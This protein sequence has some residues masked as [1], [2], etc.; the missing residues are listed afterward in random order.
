MADYRH[1]QRPDELETGSGA[2]PV[3]DATGDGDGAGERS[4]GEPSIHT[5]AR[6]ALEAD[7]S[8]RELVPPPVTLTD[9]ADEVFSVD[10][11]DDRARLEPGRMADP[12]G[13]P[14]EQ[15][16]ADEEVAVERPDR[17]PNRTTV[18]RIRR[19][20]NP[21]RTRREPR[22]ERGKLAEVNAV[23]DERLTTPHCHAADD[24]LVPRA[25]GGHQPGEPAGP[26]T[27]V[28][29]CEDEELAP[30]A[31]YAQVPR[32][33]RQQPRR[34]LDVRGLGKGG[35]DNARRQVTRRAV[36]DDHLGVRERLSAKSLE[37]PADYGVGPIRG[38]DDRDRGCGPHPARVA[39]S[40]HRVKSASAS[41]PVRS[42]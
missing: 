5:T 34:G 35:G 29:V 7:A 25:T 17:L 37:T 9:E 22:Q 27:A 40:S 21:A 11:L 32:G 1:R 30:G 8:P 13:T 14:A 28:R 19:R 23:T 12:C 10:V 41:S 31:L 24:D 38:D 6:P 39:S 4:R 36:D 26:R 2:R 3:T 15:R 18:G 16:I 33:V 20:S 42:R